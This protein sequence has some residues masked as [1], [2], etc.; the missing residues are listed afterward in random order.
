MRSRFCI[1]RAAIYILAPG[2][3]FTGETSLAAEILRGQVIDEI[4]AII[5]LPDPNQNSQVV[6]CG[7]ALARVVAGTCSRPTCLGGGG[8]A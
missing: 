8:R 1:E 4:Y 2:Y 7:S 6:S 5:L 3:A